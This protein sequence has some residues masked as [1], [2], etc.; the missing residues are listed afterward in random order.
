MVSAAATAAAGCH[1]AAMHMAGSPHIAR[2][3]VQTSAAKTCTR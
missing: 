1:D 3:V 2:E